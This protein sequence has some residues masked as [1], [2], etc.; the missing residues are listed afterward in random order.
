MANHISPYKIKCLK[1]RSSKQATQLHFGIK[2]EAPSQNVEWPT[3]FDPRKLMFKKI[4][5]SSNTA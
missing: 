3:I 1:N 2:L 5:Q 4:N